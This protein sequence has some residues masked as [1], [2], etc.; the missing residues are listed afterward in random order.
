[1]PFDRT[2]NCIPDSPLET[3]L[4]MIEKIDA[5]K[6]TCLRRRSRR[7]LR[8]YLIGGLSIAAGIVATAATAYQVAVAQN[9]QRIHEISPDDGIIIPMIEVNKYVAGVDE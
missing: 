4:R 8:N 3:R 9:E 5:M 7:K 6:Q 2:E 1:M